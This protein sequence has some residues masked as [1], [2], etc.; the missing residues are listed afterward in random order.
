MVKIMGRVEI[1]CAWT[2]LPLGTAI[3]LR[4]DDGRDGEGWGSAAEDIGVQNRE[5][6]FDFIE[7]GDPTNYNPNRNFWGT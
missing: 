4:L 3:L 5:S 2:A 7:S 6:L 1:L